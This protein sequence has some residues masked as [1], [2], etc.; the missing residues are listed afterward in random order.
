MKKFAICCLA[1]VVAAMFV[2]AAQ[3]GTKCIHLTNFCDQLELV[4]TFVGGVQGQ[5][6]VGRWD[7]VCT[8]ANDGTLISGSPNKVATQPLYP[9]HGGAAFGYNANFTFKT[10]P[11]PTRL[12]DLYGT[13]DGITNFA[14]QLSQPWSFTA[15]HCNPLS[16]A[17]QAKPRALGR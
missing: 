10:L 14:F 4:Q 5:E 16:P 12:F 6:V 9:F 3:A 15:G 13:G 11:G 7:W 8:F 2:P 17:E 1:V